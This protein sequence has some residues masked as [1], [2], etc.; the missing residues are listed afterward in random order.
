MI[1]DECE[2]C[3]HIEGDADSLARIE[4][5]RE[6]RRLGV[7]PAVYP[8]V[9]SMGRLPGVKV[10]ASSEGDE[11]KHMAP[12][13]QYILVGASALGS[14][15][16]IVAEVALFN[17]GSSRIYWVVEVEY[18]RQMTFDLKAGFRKGR[19]DIGPDEVVEARNDLRLLASR[20]ESAAVVA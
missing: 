6:A 18:Q 4:L 16:R 5:I 20:L 12:F 11:A 2:L 13:V 9:R 10:V 19:P 8:I 7:D 1:V 14:L 3:G 15:E 17:R